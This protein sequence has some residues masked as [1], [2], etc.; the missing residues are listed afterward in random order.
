MGRLENDFGMT[1]TT[2]EI[3]DKTFLDFLRDCGQKPSG[4]LN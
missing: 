4:E 1:T 3:S 2:P